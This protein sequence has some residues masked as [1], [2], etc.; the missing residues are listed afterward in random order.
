[1]ATSNNS[2]ASANFI[3]T[4]RSD[5]NG[6]GVKEDDLAPMTKIGDNH[7]NDNFKPASVF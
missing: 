4:G 3:A 6:E 5:S 7:R 1:M 2:F